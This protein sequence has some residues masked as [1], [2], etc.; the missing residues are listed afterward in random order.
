VKTDFPALVLESGGVGN[1]LRCA[2]EG[3]GLSL[4]EASQATMIW[5][6]YLQALEDD[7]PPDDFPAPIY[8]RFFLREYA[9][10]LDIP[11]AP[12]VEALDARW[13]TVAPDL[14]ALP[15]VKPPRRW[16]SKLTTAAGVVALAALV[17]FSVVSGRGSRGGVRVGTLPSTPP[18]PLTGSVLGGGSHAHAGRPTSQ[19]IKA[20]LTVTHRCWIRAEADGKV[21]AERTYEPGEELSLRARHSLDLSFGYAPGVR[22]VVNGHHVASGTV[23]RRDLSF[24]FRKGHLTRSG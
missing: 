17:A 6:R 1:A 16:V 11:A 7:A 20:T 9:G 23:A 8:A 22:I 13:G 5:T 3:R 12:L 2:R 15:Q 4:C 24:S 19:G 14:R 18:G 10:Y 21:V